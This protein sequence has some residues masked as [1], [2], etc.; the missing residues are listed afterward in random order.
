[1][2]M[3][4]L[5]GEG[6]AFAPLDAF[7]ALGLAVVHSPTAAAEA[8]RIAGD[9]RPDAALV[10][11]GG[12]IEA[13]EIGRR[14]RRQYGIP[15]LHLT[16]RADEDRLARA[17][18]AEPDGYVDDVTSRRQLLGA[19]EIAIRQRR[20]WGVPIGAPPVS[21]RADRLATLGT[22]SAAL[23]HQINNP[24]TWVIANLGLVV[25]TVDTLRRSLTV[26]SA[27]TPRGA[28]R[29]L[30]SAL[31]A[32]GHACDGAERIR[33]I[34][35]DLRDFAGPDE[36]ERV[37]LDVR[38][39]LD[40]AVRVCGNEIRHRARV[41]LLYQEVPAVDGNPTQLGQAFLN[42]LLNATQA[43]PTGRADANEIRLVTGTDVDGGALVEVHDTGSG[44]PAE[45]LDRIF[46][47]FFTTRPIGTGRG[48]GLSVAHG[49]FTEHGG[50]IG[51]ESRLG[52]GTVFR[53][54]LPPTSMRVRPPTSDTHVHVGVRRGRVVVID[55][56]P[57]VLDVLGHLLGDDH[58][59]ETYTSGRAALARLFSGPPCDVIL[60]DLMMPDCSGM[61]VYEAI[62]RRRPD[63]VD[64]IVF[65]T[66]GAFTERAMTFL[67]QVPNVRLQKPFEVRRL[68]EEIR[69]RV[70]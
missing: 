21:T 47:P 28:S 67:Q 45:Y 27:A 34:V 9:T 26:Q 68:L 53:I 59:V 33:R 52:L 65:I 8:L 19:L 29:N 17:R 23:A 6:P 30:E 7:R 1:M 57:L 31:T 16:G 70:I 13:I 24:F 5:V 60:C 54:R 63:L 61:D 62:A 22:I 38:E 41:R 15:I 25:D 56:E 49:I 10:D 66:G 39:L 46:E 12:D 44:I 43:I 64:H 2:T 20:S 36:L 58:D 42:V 14:I 37:P 3:L 51:V 35:A 32:I 40:G 4:L 11:V 69:R 50:D 18:A 48:M 55:D